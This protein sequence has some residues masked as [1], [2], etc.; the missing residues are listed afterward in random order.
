[1]SIE[2]VRPAAVMQAVAAPEEQE[3]ERRVASLYHPV[4]YFESKRRILELVRLFCEHGFM[5]LED[6]ALA[7]DRSSELIRS[8]EVTSLKRRIR[9][10]E[11]EVRGQRLATDLVRWEHEGTES[12]LADERE[13]VRESLVRIASL[14]G[15]LKDARRTALKLIATSRNSL[16]TLKHV[17]DHLATETYAVGALAPLVHDFRELTQVVQELHALAVVKASTVPLGSRP[18]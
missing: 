16:T 11:E 17:R 18:R 2:A 7:M 10:L 6:V 8:E 4:L 5:S 1:M 15:Q 3:A 9:D 13:L 14:E 12:A